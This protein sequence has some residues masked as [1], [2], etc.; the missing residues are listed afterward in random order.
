MNKYFTFSQMPMVSSDYWN[1]V[2]APHSSMESDVKGQ[3][4]LQTLGENMSVMLKA[5]NE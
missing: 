2:F 5:K 1:M 4:I 3:Q